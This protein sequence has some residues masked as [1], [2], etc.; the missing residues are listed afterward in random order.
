[1]GTLHDIFVH[2]KVNKSLP[3][4][5]GKENFIYSIIIHNILQLTA[6]SEKFV[7][8]LRTATQKSNIII[9]HK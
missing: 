8:V 1:M 2:K 5:F 7:F 3:S 6:M 9:Y 4:I